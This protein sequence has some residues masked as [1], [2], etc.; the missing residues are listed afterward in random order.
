MASKPIEALPDVECL[1]ANQICIIDCACDA[2]RCDDHEG[3]PR[4]Q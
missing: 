4:R 1:K 3:L 2:D